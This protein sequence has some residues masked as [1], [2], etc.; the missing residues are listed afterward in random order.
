MKTK[1][2]NQMIKCFERNWQFYPDEPK[3]VL[4]FDQ[5]IRNV[6]FRFLKMSGPPSKLPPLHNEDSNV[7][8]LDQIATI[9]KGSRIIKKL[10]LFIFPWFEFKLIYNIW[11]LKANDPSLTNSAYDDSIGAS[12]NQLP[13]VKKKRR[14]K[15]KRPENEPSNADSMVS[16]M[17]TTNG[18]PRK[19]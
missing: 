9:G 11:T 16:G 5:T 4:L 10:S 15:K 8:M 14:R 13:P 12:A 7:S 18:S 17:S 1:F 2:Y 3:T 19:G 6:L